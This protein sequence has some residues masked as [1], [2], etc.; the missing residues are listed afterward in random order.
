MQV[1]R[2]LNNNDV[3]LYDLREKTLHASDRHNRLQ[4]YDINKKVLNAFIVDKGHENGNEAHI[5]LVNG[6]ILIFNERTKLFITVKNGRPKQIK[7]LYIGLGLPIT[8]DVRK[9]INTAFENNEKHNF[10]NI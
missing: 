6:V 10:N 3:S 8:A 9:A 4:A 5:L 7:D 2:L 1:L